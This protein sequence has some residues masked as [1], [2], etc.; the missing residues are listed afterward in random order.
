LPPL[1]GIGGG[2]E[3]RRGGGGDNHR[4]EYKQR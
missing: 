1:V 2:G 4:G 3:R